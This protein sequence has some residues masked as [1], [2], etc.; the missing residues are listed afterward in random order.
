MFVVTMAMLVVW[1]S[2]RQATVTG[3]ERA[4][5]Q[6]D[7]SYF[8]HELGKNVPVWVHSGRSSY[9]LGGLCGGLSALLGIGSGAIM[10]P[11][12][13]ILHRLPLKVA[14]ATSSYVTAVFAACG[15][16]VQRHRIDWQVAIPLMVGVYAGTFLAERY[17]RRLKGQTIAWGL[18]CLLFIIGIRMWV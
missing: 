11:A 7:W 3:G 17:L 18:A 2:R 13:T 8:D 15:M 10:V 5:Q 4:D 12:L 16:L 1:R 9:V 14:A 6:P